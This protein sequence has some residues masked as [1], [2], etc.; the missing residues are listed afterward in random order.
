MSQRAARLPRPCSANVIRRAQIRPVVIQKGADVKQIVHVVPQRFEISRQ[1]SRS[2]DVS[3][4]DKM[5]GNPGLSQSLFGDSSGYFIEIHADH[6]QGMLIEDGPSR[7]SSFDYAVEMLEECAVATAHVADA[8]GLLLERAIENLD[9]N[10]VH[11]FEISGM[12]AAAAPDVHSAIN[13]Q[14]GTG[15]I[16]SSDARISEKKSFDNVKERK[17]GDGHAIRWRDPRCIVSARREAKTIAL[18][19]DPSLSSQQIEYQAQARVIPR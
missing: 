4:N 9:D 2:V 7:G 11:L 5:F 13:E 15:L 17:I 10:F 14:L 18:S 1:Q 8:L 6:H 3:G 12:R 16:D 19:R